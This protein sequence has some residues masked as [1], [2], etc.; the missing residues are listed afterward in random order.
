MKRKLIF[1]LLVALALTPIAL[2]QARVS[3]GP[4]TAAS[5]PAAA[6]LSGGRY[7]LTSAA[8]QVS[9]GGGYYLVGPASPGIRGD[10]CCCTYLPCVFR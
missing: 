6:V 5:P 9:S 10:G 1:L 7:H 3:A 4:D 8:W 2:T